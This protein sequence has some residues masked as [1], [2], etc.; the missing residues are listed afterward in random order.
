MA[1][2]YLN[3]SMAAYRQHQLSLGVVAKKGEGGA[4]SDSAPEERP[5]VK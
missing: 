3:G 4:S 2:Q 5:S 1:Y